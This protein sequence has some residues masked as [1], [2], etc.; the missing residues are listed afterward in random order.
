MSARLR[1]TILYSGILAATLFMFG[2]FLYFYMAHT[3]VTEVDQSIA[4]KARDVVR[5]IRVVG[6]FPLPLQRVVLPDV[7]VFA[8]PNIFLQA[9]DDKGEVVARSNNLGAQM[10]P[11]REG[12]LKR[13]A[14]QQP[15]FE[16]TGSGMSRLRI[17]IVPLVWQDQVL[18]LLQVGQSLVPV[19]TALVRLRLVLLVSSFLTVFL[20]AALGWVL[21]KTVL[22]PIERVADT[23]EAIQEARDLE[24]RVP[25]QGPRDEIGRLVSAI[26]EMLS[27]LGTAYRRLAEAHATQRR[28][29]A[30]ASH[31]L[32]TPL[33]TIR[34]NVELLKK[35]GDDEPEVRAEALD[36]IASEAE[37]L[38]RLVT[39]LLT[40]ARADAGAVIDKEPVSLAALLDEV[41]RQARLLAGNH[42]LEVEG[43]PEEENTD[44]CGNGTLLKQVL[45]I[46]IENAFKYTPEGGLVTLRAARREQEVGIAVSDTGIG[47]A[48]AD[49]PHIFERFYR[50]D[51]ARVGT[52]T[53]LGLSIAREIMESH[54]GRIELSSAPGEGSTFTVWLPVAAPAAG[55]GPA[56][57]PPAKKPASPA[58]EKDEAGGE[59]V[60][61]E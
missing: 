13:A 8:T 16:T 44:V 56:A 23:V 18:G 25:Y 50:A 35:M 40:L 31:E 24:R 52:G 38:S 36:D 59:P 32:R 1:L 45:L 28:F 37:R 60:S 34:G 3:M 12:T 7:D 9:A 30:D 39:D 46:L 27:R 6:G 4:K 51:R 10:L 5:S 15:F 22:R 20:A 55:A 47:I 42:R 49:L 53:G 21:A 2:V 14:G 61:P 29:V 11:L 58:P 26:N 17:Y 19:E 43:F 54:G 41:S 57:G 48:E 33:T